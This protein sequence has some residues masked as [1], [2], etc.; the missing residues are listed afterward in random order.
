MIDKREIILERKK[1][2]RKDMGGGTIV[3][4]GESGFESIRKCLSLCLK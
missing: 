3:S 4:S 1:K 2:G